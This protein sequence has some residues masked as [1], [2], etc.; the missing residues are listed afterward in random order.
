MELRAF[1][2]SSHIVIDARAIPRPP[3]VSTRP[4]TDTLAAVV[5]KFPIL[6]LFTP[7]HSSGELVL[8][9]AAA[10]VVIIR[11]W[12]LWLIVYRRGQ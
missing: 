2:W 7:S 4:L 10:S 9:G 12:T 3:G 5:P 1:P 8:S 11:I 6:K